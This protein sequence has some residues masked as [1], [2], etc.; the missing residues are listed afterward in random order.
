MNQIIV[1][2]LASLTLI[3]GRV[4]D[5]S[6]RPV[7]DVCVSDGANIVRTDR[8]GRYSLESD[9][10]QEFV[11]V[12]TPS[13]Y[14]VPLMEDGLQP[15]FW[16]RLDGTSRQ[17]HDFTLIPQ[18]Q[19]S[20]DVIFVTDL[21]IINSPF[22]ND[23]EHLHNHVMPLVRHI[24]ERNA[25]DGS[26]VI[27]LNLG[28]VSQ[29]VYWYRFD[30]PID[31]SYAHLCREGF[32]GPLYS[33]PGN[34]DNDPEVIG[35]NVDRRAEAGYRRC[36][37]PTYYSMNIGRDH[38]IMMDNTIYTN[39]PVK[40]AENR[41]RGKRSFE[42]A[43]TGTQMRW[44]EQDLA[45]APEGSTIRICAHESFLFEY[46]EGK[47]TQFSRRSQ[48]DSLVAMLSR[49][50][51]TMHA[52]TGHTH[53][54][55]WARNDIFPQ[56]EDLM[57]P[58]SSGNV[59]G[60]GKDGLLGIDASDAGLVSGHFSN[61]K[62][63][64]EYDTYLYGQKWMRTYD[65]NSVSQYYRCDSLARAHVAAMPM[66]TDYS[67]PERY[68]NWVYANIWMYRPDDRVVML[69]NGRELQ[70]VQLIQSD[71]LMLVSPTYNYNTYIKPQ[72]V[73]CYHLFGAQACEADSDITIRVIAK[74]GTVRHE[75]VM[76]RPKSFS[77]DAR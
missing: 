77:Q 14:T 69:E 64:Y 51:G 57:L 59:W 35:D 67:D 76:Q 53:R 6:G 37:G 46:P 54:M 24:H 48:M 5:Q 19:S 68:R 7:R 36:F 73:N 38:W 43:F 72:Y 62:A 29:D 28:D 60:S 23:L 52:Y 42:I 32:P 63:T 20:Y 50:D 13:G 1:A 10:D 70:T 31:S 30:C 49:Q 8:R 3:T 41:V 61:G 26:P 33:L 16:Q 39:T 74:D 34:H 56:V 25:A 18:D 15:A 4:T 17:R 71:P 27:A 9:G 58:A 22:H 45:C 11:F 66:R 65:M 2:L 40:K 12:I 44:L 75:E 47:G 21:H 55:Q